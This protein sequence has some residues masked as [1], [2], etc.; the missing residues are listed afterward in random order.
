MMKKLLGLAA[1]AASV[2]CDYVPPDEEFGYKDGPSK[3]EDTDI[4]EIVVINDKSTNSA[5]P[6][7]AKVDYVNRTMSFS[8]PVY[9]NQI[10]VYNKVAK[11]KAVGK[12]SVVQKDGKKVDYEV[13][14]YK[15][16]GN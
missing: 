11:D 13:H 6:Q 4:G 14:L 5:L 16:F 3:V 1:I 12:F 8:S 9:G 15:D 2:G 7:R 10:V